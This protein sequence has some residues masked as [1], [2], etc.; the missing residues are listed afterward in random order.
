MADVKH[1]TWITG[2]GIV[3]CLGEGT[4]AHWQA[5]N[6]PAPAPDVRS[7]PSRATERPKRRA[8]LSDARSVRPSSAPAG[9]GVATWPLS[10]WKD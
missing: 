3:S 4:E 7:S 9:P 8:R 1:E 6:A 10:C 2:I 5:L